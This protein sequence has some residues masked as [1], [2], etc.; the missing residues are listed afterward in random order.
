[1]KNLSTTE[2]NKNLFTGFPTTKYFWFSFLGGGLFEF[3]DMFHSA[4]EENLIVFLTFFFPDM[5]DVDVGF[6]LSYV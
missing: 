6:P 5:L 1:M 3:V 2:K 4:G